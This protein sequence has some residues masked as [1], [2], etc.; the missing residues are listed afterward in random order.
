[1][2]N[3]YVIIYDSDVYKNA[4]GETNHAKV[5]H[6]YFQESAASM[7]RRYGMRFA[8]FSV[9]EKMG[10]NN[11]PV[12]GFGSTTFNV[13]LAEG[14]DTERVNLKDGERGLN[15]YEASV[16]YMLVAN[17]K[18]GKAKSIVYSDAVRFFKQNSNVIV[19]SFGNYP[20]NM[21][22]YWKSEFPQSNLTD[23]PSEG[24]DRNAISYAH[25]ADSNSG[26]V[27]DFSHVSNRGWVVF[28]MNHKKNI[29]HSGVYQLFSFEKVRY[30]NYYL[31][32]TYQYNLCV[33]VDASKVSDIAL[34]LTIRECAHEDRQYFYLGGNYD[35]SYSISSKFV[36]SANDHRRYSQS[37]LS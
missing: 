33:A 21:I 14:L 6:H 20:V 10:G 28:R 8:G 15:A 11:L 29:K 30:E 32:H 9:K 27:W 4:P 22:S 35:G 2:K 24:C 1:M 5:A 19:S 31:I 12:I 7:Q 13:G 34:G 18:N 36:V 25:I 3:G 23:R 17:W 16:V 26:M 37:H